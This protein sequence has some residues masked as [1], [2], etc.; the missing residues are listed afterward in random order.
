MLII[1]AFLIGFALGILVRFSIKKYAGSIV[2]YEKEDGV[3]LY[4]LEMDGDPEELDKMKE[5]TFRIGSSKPEQIA[6]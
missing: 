4:S 3:K 1:L 5:V 6:S 2:I